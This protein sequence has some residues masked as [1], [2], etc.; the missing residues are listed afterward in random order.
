MR[1]DG[2][3]S[4]IVLALMALAALMCLAAADAASVL[5]ARA[6]AQAA[7]DAAALA[8]AAA[9]W[10]FGARGESPSEAARRVAEANGAVLEEC[11][12]VA[13]DDEAHVV[14]SVP[15]RVRMLGVAPHSVRAQARSRI[16]VARVFQPA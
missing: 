13:R 7:A 3:A 14:V 12:C 5:V 16:D 2:F 4:A 11:A 15:T 1:E 8:A 9:Q 6:R 10:P